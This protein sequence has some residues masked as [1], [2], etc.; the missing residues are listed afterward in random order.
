VIFTAGAFRAA[1]EAKGIVVDGSIKVATT[2][3]QSVLVT[4]IPS[5]PLSRLVSLM[6][7]ESINHYAE[8]LWRDAAR[9]PQRTIVGSAQT[10]DSTLQQFL[11]RQVG[12]A[13]NAV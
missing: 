5:P 10:A 1:L 3:A 9:G 8:M 7:R 4:G 6:N 13:P 11:L 12:T 2:P